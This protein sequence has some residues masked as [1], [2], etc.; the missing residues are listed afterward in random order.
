VRLVIIS[1]TPHYRRGESVVGWGPTVREIDALGELFDEVVHV[2]PLHDGRAPESALPYRCAHLRIRAV[3]PAGGERLRDKAALLARLPG[4]ARAIAAELRPADVVHVRCPAAISLVGLAVVSLGGRPRACWVKYAGAWEPR[5]R[6]VWSNR[7]QRW[8]LRKGWHRGVVT[9]N[10]AWAGQPPHVHSFLNPCLSDEELAAAGRQ[11]RDKELTA[12]LRLLFVGRLERD[13]GVD[14]ALR[15]LAGL[16]E[17]RVPATLEIAGDG[18]ERR[19]LEAAAAEQGVGELVT[20]SGWL[21]REDVGARYARAHLLVL[22]SRSE[23]WPKVLSEGMAY[24]VVPLAG[25]VGSVPEVLRRLA[26]GRA[27]DPHDAGAFLE[28]AAWYIAHPEEWRRESER[29]RLAAGQFTYARYLEAVAGLLGP[30]AVRAGAI[31]ET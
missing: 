14:T 10:G 21:P 30:Q 28:A 13:K 26:T 9:V 3:K 17:R 16:R 31:C 20:F 22:P 18:P 25:A 19:S 4:Y 5:R 1:H 11:A 27:L 29:G 24:G 6:D 2:A 8:W 7:L 23:G 15:V 12:P